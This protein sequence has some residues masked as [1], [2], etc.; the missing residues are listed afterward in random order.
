LVVGGWCATT[1]AVAV[2]ELL[3]L[4]GISELHPASAFTALG[5]PLGCL[6][7]MTWL[8]Q[9]TAS[10]RRERVHRVELGARAC[11]K[12]RYDMSGMMTLSC[13]ECG[14]TYTLGSLLE[15]HA[16]RQ[17]PESLS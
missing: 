4:G 16:Q 17:A 11:P 1:F 8:W 5:V 12:C 3:H 9:E 2:I 6:M 7:A 15:T 13:P 10:E 14:T